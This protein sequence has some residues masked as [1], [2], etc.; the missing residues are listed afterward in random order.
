MFPINAIKAT[1][2]KCLQG[3]VCFILGVHKYACRYRDVIR[4]PQFFQ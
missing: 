3:L 4:S 2:A 1:V